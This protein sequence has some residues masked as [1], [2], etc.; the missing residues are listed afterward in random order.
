M[1]RRTNKGIVVML[2]IL[3]LG[4]VAC[5]E[6]Q[7]ERKSPSKVVGKQQKESA[8]AQRK[9]WEASPEGIQFKKWESSPEGKKVRACLTKIQPRLKTFAPLKAVVTSLTFERVK[10]QKSGPKWLLVAI[11]GDTYMLQFSLKD[12][13]RLK[14]LNV[15]DSL[16]IKSRYGSFSPNHPYLILSSDYIAKG[17]KV[18]YKRDTSKDKK[19]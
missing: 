11:D 2:A 5:K 6:N 16:I 9:K 15:Q 3:S 12:F 8:M 14:S 17:D 4:I 7:A 13:Q 10:G 1:K 19:C 18:L